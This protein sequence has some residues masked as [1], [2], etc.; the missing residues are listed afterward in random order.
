MMNEKKE[1]TQ[2]VDLPVDF[3][4]QVTSRIIEELDK[5]VL[6]WRKPWSG[7]YKG[8]ASNYVSGNE[9][10]GI[11]WL[12]L[13]FLSPYTVPYYLTFNQ[14]KSLG[15]SIKKG[16]KAETIYFFNCYF[17]DEQNRRLSEEDGIEAREAGREVRQ[18][19]FLKRYKVFN[20]ESTRGIDWE[21]PWSV[22]KDHQPI[23]TCELLISGLQSVVGF[24]EIDERQAYYD[25]SIDAINMPSMSLF[26]TVENYYFTLFHELGHWTGHKSRLKRF[27]D[28]GTPKVDMPTY[29]EEEL[30]AEICACALARITSIEVPTTFPNAAAYIQHW[31]E[32]L[33]A[34]RKA[35]FIAANKAQKAVN[36]LLDLADTSTLSILTI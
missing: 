29:A 9:Y 16:A 21:Q 18:I 5:G 8:F 13:N 35:I 30:V 11:N 7:S 27:E 14:V 23:E 2:K 1:A 10:T 3:Y 33:K 4:S 36:Y 20:I 12:L 25:S 6:P 32:Y 15:G 34:D 26:D 24:M 22:Y 19:S 17:K 28:S 31:L